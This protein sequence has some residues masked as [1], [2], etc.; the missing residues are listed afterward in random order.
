MPLLTCHS[1][2]GFAVSR[3]TGLVD[4]SPRASGISF[5]ASYFSGFPSHIVHVVYLTRKISFKMHK[6]MHRNSVNRKLL[7]ILKDY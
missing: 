2:G 6:S 5:K 7:K 1:E 4:F 3:V